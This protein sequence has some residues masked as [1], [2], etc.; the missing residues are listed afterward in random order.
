MTVTG[1][2][3]KYTILF[4]AYEILI[5][6]NIEDNTRK[7]IQRLSKSLKL[8][9]ASIVMI[10][11]IIILFSGVNLSPWINS[12]HTFMFFINSL[13][14]ILDLIYSWLYNTSIINR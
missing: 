4:D 14:K 2:I 3:F 1:T 5:M 6:D 8:S 10:I 12:N 13:T 9:N 11:V 7:F